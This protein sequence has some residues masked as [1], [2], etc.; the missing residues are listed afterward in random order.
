MRGS[1]GAQPDFRVRLRGAAAGE[2][3][4]QLRDVRYDKTL[5]EIGGHRDMGIMAPDLCILGGGAAGL[6]AAALAAEAGAAVVV[7]ER[8]EP[9]AANRHAGGLAAN[10]LMAAA[11]R[12]AAMNG[13]AA[14]GVRAG[15]PKIDF[16]AVQDRLQEQAA[17][18]AV[19]DSPDRWRALGIEMIAAAAGFRDHRTVVAG[20]I[21]IRARHFAIATGSAPAIPTIPGLEE[22]GYLTPETVFDLRVCPRHLVILGAGMDAL[23]LGQAYRRL[24]AD[25]TV[26]ALDGLLEDVDPDA[27]AILLGR[28]CAEGV[29]IRTGGVMEIRRS[30]GRPQVAGPDGEVVEA[31]HLLVMAGRSPNLAA[32]NLAAAGVKAD[33]RGILVDSRMRTSNKRIYAMGDVAG[34]ECS[35]HAA[36]HQAALVVRHALGGRPFRARQPAIPRV[37]FTDP[38]IAQVGLTETQ[39]RAGRRAIRVLRWPFHE[40]DRARADGA[41]TGFVKIVADA[42]GVI[43]GATIIGGPAAEL[44]ATWTLAVDQ[45]LG[46]ATMADLVLPYPTF[47]EAGPAALAGQARSDLTRSALRRIIGR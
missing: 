12:V 11:A 42:R 33:T 2:A 4:F 19:N 41:E 6:R 1:G 13:A 34:G 31:S 43:L 40:N 29:D 8:G 26:M 21:E 14:F 36:R 7:V 35:V 22:A 3:F 10:V 23:E 27:A 17:A 25:V 16:M 37:A 44:I 45:R 24:G 9:G 15:R 46:V 20:D 39:A 28:L 30:R 47:G 5:S 32:L 18:L 38:Q